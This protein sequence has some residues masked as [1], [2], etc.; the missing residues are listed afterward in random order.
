M[1][2][3]KY[4]EDVHKSR[5]GC[6]SN[7]KRCCRSSSS[8]L[9]VA[10]I[11]D[12]LVL[13]Q[14]LKVM[15]IG[16]DIRG[17]LK[18]SRKSVMSP[19]EEA[20]LAAL[21]KTPPAEENT[22]LLPEDVQSVQPESLLKRIDRQI[23]ASTLEV[24]G[25]SSPPVPSVV[26]VTESVITVSSERVVVT[27]V[28][29]ESSDGSEKE[30]APSASSIKTERQTSKTGKSSTA[31]AGSVGSEEEAPSADAAAADGASSARSS[32][33]TSR[34]PG[35]RAKPKAKLNPDD[36]GVVE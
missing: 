23:N 11:G 18:L 13:G 7:L 28:S 32:A 26:E 4:C 14:V 25:I 20:E 10:R 19:E 21:S 5:S 8:I 27:T 24:I 2:S 16:R 34:R 9:Q 17:N 31:K 30:D 6:G 22:S 35:G 33:K 3:T 29:S 12:V 15:C 36:A 1:P